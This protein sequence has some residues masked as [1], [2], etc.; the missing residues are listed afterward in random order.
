MVMDE[1]AGTLQTYELTLNEK[2]EKEKIGLNEK[3]F[4]LT[5]D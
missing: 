4:L 3:I 5:K 2:L 1:L